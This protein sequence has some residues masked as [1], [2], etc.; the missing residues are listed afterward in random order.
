MLLK[1]DNTIANG[2]DDRI[3]D[4]CVCSMDQL[5]TLGEFKQEKWKIPRMRLNRRIKACNT[6]TW[7]RDLTV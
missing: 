7:M 4:H 1:Q 6:V 2:I 5:E 3:Q